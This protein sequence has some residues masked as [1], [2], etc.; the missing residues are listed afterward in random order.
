M[1]RATGFFMARG[2]PQRLVR[3]ASAALLMSW[4]GLALA[5]ESSESSDSA[6]AP[7]GPT[8]HQ[9]LDAHRSAQELKQN[10]N[11]VEAQEHLRICSAGTCP[12]P[13]IADCG[14]W[15]TQLEQTT[16][17]VVVEVRVDGKMALDAKVF[18]DD[19]PIEDLTHAVKANP[20]RH[21]VRVELEGFPTREQEVVLQEGQRMRLVPVEFR[22]EQPEATALPSESASPAP[23]YERPVPVLVYPLLAVGVGGLASFGVFSYLGKSE[24]KE[25]EDICK[26]W[27]Q[28]SD[29]K[30]MKQNYLVADISLG[31]GGA[32]LLGAGI[33]YLARPRVELPH[34]AMGGAKFGVE[35]GSG[36]FGVS[37]KR[38]W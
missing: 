16:P 13:I 29:M 37:M 20:G 38:T 34:P 10:G 4:P 26:P 22:T 24:Q 6:G 2:V 15:I 30:T 35:V 18:L 21:V 9:C 28:D 19:Q 23:Q 25:L 17:S 33:L 12:G 32:A 11:F 31:V 1:S 8:R 36:S 7:E 5:E 3:A 14:N 27:C